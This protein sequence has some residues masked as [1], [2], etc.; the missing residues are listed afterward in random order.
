MDTATAAK[1]AVYILL[2]SGLWWSGNWF[3][4]WFLDLSG[5][6]KPDGE[7][8]NPGL[9]D[10]PVDEVTLRGG[11]YIG[12]LERILIM[13]GI[14]AQRWELIAG[15]IALKT[16]ARYKELDKQI[17]AEYF[18]IGS[19]AS[20]LWAIVITFVAIMY[21]SYFGFDLIA[22]LQGVSGRGT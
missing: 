7:E 1:T 12:V 6:P 20:I 15:V 18:L 17:N 22:W 4:R 2:F 13:I 9:G 3:C 16:V 19:L 10:N 8:S 21:D 11:R 14:A 5:S